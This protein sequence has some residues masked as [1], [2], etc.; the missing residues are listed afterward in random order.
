MPKKIDPYEQEIE[1]RKRLLASAKRWGFYGD[2]KQKFDYWDNQMRNCT[3][4]KELADM[5]KIAVVDIFSL[6]DQ[7]TGL[8]IDGE[9]VIPHDENYKGED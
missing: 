4:A 1:T 8:T 7:K 5:K 9:V 6:Y 2:L 3:N